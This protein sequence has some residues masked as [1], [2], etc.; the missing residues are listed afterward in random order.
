MRPLVEH[1]MLESFFS[2]RFVEAQ[3]DLRRPFAQGVR[4][5][6]ARLKE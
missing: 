4:P 2:M 3:R 1:A 6:R 5:R